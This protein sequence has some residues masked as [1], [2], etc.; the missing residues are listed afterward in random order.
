MNFFKRAMTTIYRQP[1]KFCIFLILVILMGMLTSGAISIRQAII[2][3]EQNLRRRMPSIA[4]VIQDF[5]YEALSEI[6]EETGEWSEVEIERITP[7]LIREIG[8]FPQVKIYDYTIDLS[9][10]VT[11]RGL[12]MWENPKFQS[13]NLGEYDEELGIRLRIRGVSNSDFIETREG[14]IDLISGRSFYEHEIHNFEER[15]PALVASGFAEINSL[16]IGSVFNVQVIVFGDFPYEAEILLEE[17]FPLEVIG[18]FNPIYRAV[19]EDADI[20]QLFQSDRHQMMM[21]HRIYVPNAVAELMFN[22]RAQNVFE[23]DEV[24]LH[25]FFILNDPMDIHEF[26]SEI[27]KLPGSWRV[28]DL[29]SSFSEI[30]ASMESILDI[31]NLIFFLS[32]GATLLVISLLV[33]LL[34]RERK[35]EIGIYLALG[36]EKRKIIAQMCFELFPLAFIGIII[37]LFLGN[38]IANQISQEILRQDLARGDVITGEWNPLEELGYRFELTHEEMLENYDVRLNTRVVSYFISIGLAL[39]VIS[40]TTPIVHAT[41]V[42]P[43]KLLTLNNN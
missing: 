30:S 27:E 11:G 13:P 18:I 16:D 5:D 24:F 38:V 4:T 34:M 1:I 28:M 20:G 12:N 41:N 37:A 29:S 6:Y 42:N 15:Y 40:T 8:A 10:G 2:N 21:Q 23:V 32:I 22:V 14:L 9:W 25:N 3:T 43:K 26:V 19:A 33:I 36:E 7:E 39:I 17:T 35:H 31:A